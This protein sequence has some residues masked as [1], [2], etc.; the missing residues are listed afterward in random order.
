[1]KPLRRTKTSPSAVR[2]RMPVSEERKE[3]NKEAS[4]RRDLILRVGTPRGGP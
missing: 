3:V 4:S 1:L 2:S